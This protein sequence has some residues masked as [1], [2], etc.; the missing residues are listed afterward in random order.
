MVLKAAREAFQDGNE[1]TFTML[2]K[3]QNK[4]PEAECVCVCVFKETVTFKILIILQYYRCTVFVI[5]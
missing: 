5:K 3:C 4:F 2:S 1:N